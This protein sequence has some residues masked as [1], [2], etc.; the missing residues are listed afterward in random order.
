MTDDIFD[1]DAGWGPAPEPA[2]PVGAFGDVLAEAITK[3]PDSERF[4]SARSA[5]LDEMWTM[6]EDGVIGEMPMQIEDMIRRRADD[7][8]KAML[9]GDE[10]MVRRHLKLDGYTGRNDASRFDDRDLHILIGDGL[11]EGG[12]LKI[13]AAIASA[14]RDLIE[15]ERIKDLEDQLASMVTLNVSLKKENQR[16]RE[17]GQRLMGD[18]G[19][20]G[21][22]R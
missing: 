20:V 1:D 13:R 9:L 11:H 19:A 15:Q 10:K 6:I 7:A 17:L 14:N 18:S 16:L 8:I 21:G 12:I 4:Q 22:D 2:D 5:F 3:L